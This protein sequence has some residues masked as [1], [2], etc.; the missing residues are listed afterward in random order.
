MKKIL[1]FNL[2]CAMLLAA[3]T[4]KAAD[5]RLDAT[6]FP[7]RVFRM[8]IAELTG[9]AYGGYISNDKLFFCNEFYVNDLGISSLQGIEYFGFLRILDCGSNELTSLDVSKNTY[10]EKLDCGFNKLTSLDVSKN[11]YLEKLD[12][13]F[14]KLTS[15]DVSK[16]TDLTTLYC[17]NNELTSLDVSKNTSLTSLGCSDNKLTSLDVS[18]NTLLTSLGCSDNKLTSLDVSKNTALTMLLCDNNKLTL[19]AVSS[20]PVL[21]QLNCD[22]NK[23]SRLNVNFNTKL[24]RLYCNDNQLGYLNI[25]YCKDLEYLQVG[26]NRLTTIE[27]LDEMSNIKLPDPDYPYSYR[28]SFGTQT[29]TRRYYRVPTDSDT[30]W[31][32]PFNRNYDASRVQNLKIDGEAATPIVYEDWL[33]VSQDL[34]KIPT[35]VEYDF[36][37]I[38]GMDPMH[39]VVDYDV[40][41]YGIS[42]DGT[43][44]TSLHMNNIPGLK[45]GTAFIDDSD[46]QGGSLGFNKTPTLMLNNATIETTNNSKGII[47]NEG[48]CQEFNIRVFGNCFIINRNYPI[49]LSLDV[50][51]TTNIIGSGTLN[52]VNL[53]DQYNWGYGIETSTIADLRIKEG[54]TLVV[55]TYNGHAIYD[56]DGMRLYIESGSNLCLHGV[57][58]IPV[59]F[60]R[61]ATLDFGSGIGLRYPVGGYINGSSVYYADGTAV[62]GD[63]VVFGPDTQATQDLITG[64]SNLTSDPSPMRGEMYNLSGQKVGEDYKGIVIKDGRKTLIK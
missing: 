24:K 10:L 60:D 15:L 37:T 51:T 26:G 1:L 62:M 8:Y 61:N 13:R 36:K 64:I 7:D 25:S 32:L 59:Y 42:I 29:S 4:V 54:A 12:C 2:M 6:N 40:V 9:V 46:G 22:G 49:A 5:V 23:L 47:I 63:W 16:N 53:N 31:A 19:L 18:K 44:L 48:Y 56:Q 38:D 34:K 57:K 52:I 20:A 43:E 28:T 39:V 35:K 55:D 21:E 14:N 33:V 27:G 58:G 11:T 41:D 17:N 45:S 50:A 3:Q 30:C